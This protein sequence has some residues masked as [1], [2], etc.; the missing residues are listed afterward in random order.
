MRQ[1]TRANIGAAS[2]W[3][4]P[5]RTPALDRSKRVQMATKG[6]TVGVGGIVREEDRRGEYAGRK[7]WG[8]RQT[9]RAVI[10]TQMRRLLL[11]KA[12][13]QQSSLSKLATESVHCLTEIGTDL[14][15]RVPLL[16]NMNVSFLTITTVVYGS[17]KCGI[18]RCYATT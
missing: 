9:S 14:S 16:W 3:P 8:S 10:M 7:L 11:S 5:D 13:V 4:R 15:M 6:G 1:I 2:W 17:C 12:T 18:S